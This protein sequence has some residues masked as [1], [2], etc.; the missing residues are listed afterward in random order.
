MKQIESFFADF[1]NSESIVPLQR[2]DINEMFSNDDA[3]ILAIAH[4]NNAENLFVKALKGNLTPE[5]DLHKASIILLGIT[6]KELDVMG[7]MNAIYDFLGQLN[8]NYQIKWGYAI[9]ALQ[10]EL[11]TVYCAIA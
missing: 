2:E 3:V 6:S 1:L 11:F 10:K 9:N 8:H 5:V 7:V 4:C